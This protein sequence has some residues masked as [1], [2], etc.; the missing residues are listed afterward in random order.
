MKVVLAGAGAFGKKH[1]NG[2]KNIDDIE[3]VSLVGR[4]L[5]DTKVIADEHG[6][7]HA[8]TDLAE[9]LALPGVDAA[10]LCTQTQMHAAQ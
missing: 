7:S 8:T 10:I 9:A 5:E 1:L 6:I 4:Q 3:V 2:I